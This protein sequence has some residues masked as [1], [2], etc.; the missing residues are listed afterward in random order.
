LSLPYYR[1][2]RLHTWLRRLRAETRIARVLVYS[3]AMAQYV[4]GADWDG[5]RRVIDFVDV[6][7]DK[8]RQYASQM[9]APM[10][11]VYARESQRLE[12]FDRRIARSFDASL[13]VSAAEAGWFRALIDKGS[14][15][16]VH[17]NNGVDTKYFDPALDYSSPFADGAPSAVFTGAMDYWANADAVS[18]F[19]A[20][21]WPLVLKVVPKAVFYIVGSRPGDKVQSLASQGVVVTGRVPDVRPY[22]RFAEAVVAPMRIARGIQNKVLEGMA[23]AR[24][25]VVS[26]RGLEGI[27]AE[28]GKEILVAD[29]AESFAEHV[30]GL[31][32]RPH[33]RLGAA[34]R[35]LVRRDYAWEASARRLLRVVEG[36][37]E[38]QVRAP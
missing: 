11:W 1:D 24:P 15:K 12:V 27:S 35:D 26:S 7:S 31:L 18:W 6:D 10:R 8:W 21:V 37:A 34:A 29:D 25:V 19:C 36:T 28:E 17:V 33:P 23:M 9:K 3:S 5:A 2:R 38:D 14:E 4:E 13:F 20:Q 22:L 30:I 16:V 32:R